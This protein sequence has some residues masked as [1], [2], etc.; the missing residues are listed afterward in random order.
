[1]IHKA[2]SVQSVIKSVVNANANR[3][4]WVADAI[5]VSQELLDWDQMDANVS[6]GI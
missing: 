1:M 6:I 3:M 2:A 5:N 4:S